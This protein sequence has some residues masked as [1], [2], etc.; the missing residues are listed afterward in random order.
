MINSRVEETLTGL[1]LTDVAHNRIGNV[2][3]RGISGG[4]KRR[5]TIGTGLVTKPRILILDEPTSGLDSLTSREVLAASE[6]FI[7]MRH[8]WSVSD[9]LT[10]SKTLPRNKE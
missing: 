10:Q 4:Q 7:S 6:F 3:Q 5:V 8:L 9:I 1:G 2:V